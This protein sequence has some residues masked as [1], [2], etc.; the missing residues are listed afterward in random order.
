MYLSGRPG[1]QDPTVSSLLV[2]L[3]TGPA[4]AD[5]VL[6]GPPWASSFDTLLDTVD[7]R[8]KAGP[9]VPA[10]ATLSLGARSLRLLAARPVTG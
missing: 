8:P 6:P 7:E 3:N 10:G 4:E 9:A 5:V 2:L 1:P